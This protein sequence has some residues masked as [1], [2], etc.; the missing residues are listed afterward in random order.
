VVLPGW[1]DADGIPTTSLV[2]KDFVTINPDRKKPDVKNWTVQQAKARTKEPVIIY[3]KESLD[4][5]VALRGLDVTLNERYISG[6]TTLSNTET[7]W[8]FTPELPW[9]SGNYVIKIDPLVEDLAGN[10]LERLF[11][12]DLDQND[13][14]LSLKKKSFTIDFKID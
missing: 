2:K 4:Y 14:A 1:K 11:D 13:S 10:N 12:N 5:S 3:F 9:R 7:V 6:N 8:T